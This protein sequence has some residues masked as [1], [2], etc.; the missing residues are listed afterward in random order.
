MRLYT[1]KMGAKEGIL[2]LAGGI[3]LFY[4]GKA[5]GKKPWNYILQGV[6]IGV[7]GKGVYNIL[8]PVLEELTREY[9]KPIPKTH[10]FPVEIT[11]LKK[12]EVLNRLVIGFNVY[13]NYGKYFRAYGYVYLIP[14]EAGAAYGY[15]SEALILNLKPGVNKFKYNFPIPID[16]KGK[17]VYVNIVLYD[18]PC[19][20]AFCL[21]HIVGG[22]LKIYKITL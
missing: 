18:E 7:A 15:K 14:K 9:E 19:T 4:L 8:A 6:G 3:G 21:E 13:N 11:E 20:N 22:T 12:I 5:I 17:E 16:L 2:E 10:F 1:D